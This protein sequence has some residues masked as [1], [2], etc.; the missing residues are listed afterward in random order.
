M[1]VQISNSQLEAAIEVLYLH[2]NSFVFNN[3]IF[4]NVQN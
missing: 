4:N 2:L 3:V 1:M